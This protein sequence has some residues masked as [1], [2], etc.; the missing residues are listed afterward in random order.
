VAA[1]KAWWARSRY[2]TLHR[3]IC[4]GELVSC[5]GA[6][7]P[8]GTGY[9][10]A[11]ATS[12]WG[13]QLFP[14][15]A[16]SPHHSEAR[17]RPRIPPS[18]S[19]VSTRDVR[20][21]APFGL[22]SRCVISVKKKISLLA[23]VVNCITSRSSPPPLLSLFFLP[24]LLVSELGIPVSRPPPSSAHPRHLIYPTST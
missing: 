15:F 21:K 14:P 11:H 17:Q 18:S 7:V 6:V 20:R 9:L 24:F 3:M 5:G 10:A 22:V 13:M 23:R 1:P 16:P 8:D 2:H 4:M 12:H 19:P